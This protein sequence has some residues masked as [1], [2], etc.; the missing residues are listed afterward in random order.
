VVVNTAT[1][2]QHIENGCVRQFRIS[3]SHEGV[4]PVRIYH[5]TESRKPETPAKPN[6]MWASL[7]LQASTGQIL[8]AARLMSR[9]D[10]QPWSSA[11]T[12]ELQ[13][14]LSLSHSVCNTIFRKS[15]EVNRRPTHTAH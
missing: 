8:T 2:G 15:W 5:L 6:K 3:A 1:G 14:S 13:K 4:R 12:A 9:H 11:G 7:A 10:S